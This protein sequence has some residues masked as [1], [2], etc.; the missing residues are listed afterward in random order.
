MV[1]P[2]YVL[3]LKKRENMICCS[4]RKMKVEKEL[5]RENM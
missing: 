5:G 2:K 4:R 1:P 3:P